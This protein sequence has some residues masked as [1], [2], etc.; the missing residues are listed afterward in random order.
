MGIACEHCG[1]P[2]PGAGDGQEGPSFCCSG[3]RAVYHAIDSAGL[4]GFYDLRDEPNGPVE[5][6][7]PDPSHLERFDA[8]HFLDEHAERLGEG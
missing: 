2:V 4:D 7:E 1:T 5:A 6:A 8:A 3:C